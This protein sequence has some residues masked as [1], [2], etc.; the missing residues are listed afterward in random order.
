MIISNGGLSLDKELDGMDV[1]NLWQPGQYA[2]WETGDTMPFTPLAEYGYEDDTHCSAFAGRGGSQTG[3]PVAEPASRNLSREQ[4][5]GV[6]VG[7]PIGMAERKRSGGG[8]GTCKSGLHG[9][10]L[11]PESQPRRVGTHPDCARV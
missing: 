3:A 6:I 9:D 7:A 11:L 10:R 8:T 5:G 1:M 4:T 2:Y